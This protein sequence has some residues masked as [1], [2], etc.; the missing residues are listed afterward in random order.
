MFLPSVERYSTIIEEK[1]PRNFSF[2]NDYTFLF[3]EKGGKKE[4]CFSIGTCAAVFKAHKGSEDFAIRCFLR[5]ELETFRRYEE[6]NNFL[7]PKDLSW[8]VDF[9]FLDNEIQIDGQWYPVVKMDWVY[10]KPLHKFIDEIASDHSLLTVLQYK[11]VTLCKGL[12]EAGIGHGDLKYNNIFVQKKEADFTLKLIDYD[13]MFIPAFRGRNNLEPGSPGFQHPR[14]LATAF[15]ETID[16]FSVWVMLTALEVIKIDPALWRDAEQDDYTNSEHALFTVIDFINPAASRLFQKLK[17]YNNDGLNYYLNKLTAACGVKDIT[18]IEKPELYKGHAAAATPPKHTPV[19]APPA[20]APLPEEK[21]YEVEIKTVPAGKDVLVQEVKKGITPL[22]LEVLKKDFNSVAILDEGERTPVLLREGTR[23]YE[24]NL[25]QKIKEPVPAPPPVEQDEIIEFR[26]DKYTVQE[27]ELATI[28]WK[29]KGNGKIHISH[30]GEVHEKA[31]TKKVVLNHTTDY[32]LTIGSSNRSL[33]IYVQP[34]PIHVQRPAVVTPP[35]PVAAVYSAIEKEPAVQRSN[36][37]ILQVVLL[38][39]AAIAISFFAFNYI[40]GSKGADVKNTEASIT[41]P[42]NTTSP[43]GPLF[44]QSGV[45][46]FLNGLYDAY[47]N[48]NLSSIM[49]HYAPTVKEYYDSKSLTK[50]SLTSVIKNLF[51]VPASYNCTPDFKTLIVQPQD[52]HCK[53]VITINE[54]LKD[55]NNSRTD[56]YTTTIE[57]L[58]DPSYKILSEKNPG[59]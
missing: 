36:A 34:K 32:V 29:V 47:N 41:P 43:K 13:S 52:Q 3:T 20:P 17:A 48:R 59:S 4:Y 9:D 37:K 7:A 28:N 25:P 49:S 1:A 27:G 54:K 53:V 56:S 24:I 31:G 58:L 38:L 50:D 42:V 21:R 39:I 44:T 10:G 12:E 30:L 45:T 2:L 40:S 6:L 26:A 23:T 46:S 8:K 14:R 55:D 11:L 18:T 19:P 35:E 5:G 33:T 15:S 57:Y 16:R 22:V 51:I